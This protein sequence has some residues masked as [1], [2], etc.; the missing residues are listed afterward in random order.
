M[1]LLIVL[2]IK[3]P[4]KIILISYIYS[5]NSLRLESKLT[6]EKLKR[7]LGFDVPHKQV[8]EILQGLSMQVEIDGENWKIIA[9]SSR[10]D[11]EIE[12]SNTLEETIETIYKLIKDKL[13]IVNE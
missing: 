7:V 6:K 11:I 5:P 2:R 13:I 8:T 9:P 1:R 12:E 4:H 3:L 10:F